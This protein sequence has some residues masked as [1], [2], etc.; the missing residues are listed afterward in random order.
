MACLGHVLVIG[1]ETRSCFQPLIQEL[2][3]TARLLRARAA[4]ASPKN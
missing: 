3:Y 4:Q 2:V 1:L